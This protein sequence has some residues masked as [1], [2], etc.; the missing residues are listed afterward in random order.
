MSKQVTKAIGSVST[1]KSESASNKASSAAT[2]APEAV[3]VAASTVKAGGQSDMPLPTEAPSSSQGENQ[4][5]YF[6]IP[7]MFGP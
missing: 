5:Q 2:S 3:T 6:H 1:L 7:L 4:S